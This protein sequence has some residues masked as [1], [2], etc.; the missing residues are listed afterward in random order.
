MRL[1]LLEMIMNIF[2]SAGCRRVELLSDA[3]LV[4][5]ETE[6]LCLGRPRGQL[7]GAGCF[8]GTRGLHRVGGRSP[9]SRDDPGVLGLP[10]KRKV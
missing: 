7:Q 4:P 8:L 2:N 5:R 3:C 9:A 6:G 10:P 1:A